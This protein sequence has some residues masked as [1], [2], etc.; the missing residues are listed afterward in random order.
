MPTTRSPWSGSRH[1]TSGSISVL[2]KLAE[3]FQV[4]SG[5]AC[6]RLPFLVKNGLLSLWFASSL[7]I[8]SQ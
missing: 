3:L 8:W 6:L 7:Q 2:V 4:S 1:D 5:R